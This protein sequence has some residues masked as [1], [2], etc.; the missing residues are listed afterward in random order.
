MA[1]PDY[2]ARLGVAATATHQ[3]LRT[4][5]LTLARANHP[6]RFD[7]SGR[8][9]AQSKMQEINEAWSVLGVAHERTAYDAQR[10][11]AHPPGASTASGPKRGRTHFRAFDDDPIHRVEE[12]LDPTPLR[13]SKPIPRWVAMAPVG[14][15]SMAAFIFALGVLVNASAI[16]AV[17]VMAFVLGAVGF[18]MLP[19]IVM[20]RAERDPDL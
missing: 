8:D 4:A 13:G 9:R 17:G 6:D 14:L 5:Y 2:Y 12:D 15:V 18:V 20:S 3:E 19:L 10:A 16:I 7:E 1:L 11:D